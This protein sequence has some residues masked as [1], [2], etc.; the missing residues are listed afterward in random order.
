[1]SSTIAATAS[2]ADFAFQLQQRHDSQTTAEERKSRGHFGTPPAVAR[3]MA[4]LFPT[5]PQRSI[6]LLDPGAGVG[7]LTAA[8]CDRFLKL[9][10]PRQI[11]VEVWEN[12]PTLVPLLIETL[13]RC[14]ISLRSAGHVFEFT[15][16]IGDFVLSHAGESLF[17][18]AT[19]PQ[20]D[21]CVMNPPYFKLRK[22]SPHARA[23]PHVVH[24]QPN[25]YALFMAIAAERLKPGGSLVAITPRS[26]FN[27]PYFRRFRKWFFERMSLRHV[28]VFESRSD[29][30][31]DDQVLQENVVVHAERSRLTTPITVTSTF[32]REDRCATKIRLNYA[33]VVDDTGR[34]MIVRVATTTE[35]QELLRSVDALPHRLRQHGLEIST[36]PVVAFRA[37]EHL[38]HERDGHASAPLL[39]M[40]NVRP[41]VT[42]F[43][44]TK[45]GKPGHVRISRVS[46]AILL[47]AKRYV[48]MK[49]F[50]AKEEKRRLVA[51]VMEPG[52]SYSEFV[53]LENH[54]NY[55][56]RPGGELS[57]QEAIGLAA[58]LNSNAIDRYFRAVSGNTQVNAAE[59]RN[60]PLPSLTVIERLGDLV[61]TIG[62]ENADEVEKT[63]CAS[64]RLPQKSLAPTPLAA[65]RS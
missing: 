1:M 6:R 62:V 26:Y 8:L 63:V 14:R 58:I 42:T 3:L 50:T 54:L 35:E 60:L 37:T 30:F 7:T 48:L 23:F 31:R 2:L 52:D 15:V 40:H 22:E 65:G 4:D 29:A 25:I 32:G 55:V 49:R 53:G 34:D 18:D 27:G 17:D 43:P 57:R 13:E 59:I 16:Q 12:D 47:P 51:G 36:G 61:C 33:E 20:F 38:L 45:N 21:L 10:T 46:R 44:A 11:H 24:G 39:W 19:V 41:S 64:L 5:F 28:H 56:H 9:K